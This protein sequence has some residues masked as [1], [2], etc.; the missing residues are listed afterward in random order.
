LIESKQKY[1]FAVMIV[2]VR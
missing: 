2:F 1:L